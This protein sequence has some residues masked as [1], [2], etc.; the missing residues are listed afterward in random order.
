MK[1]DTVSLVI[2]SCDRFDL[3]EKTLESFYELN[4]II[5]IEDSGKEKKLNKVL[6]KFNNI[7]F[8]TIVNHEK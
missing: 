8:L 1:S 4:Q 6:N 2:T 3:L 7:N 5:I